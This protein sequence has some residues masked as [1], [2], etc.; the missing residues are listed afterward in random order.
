MI[1]TKVTAIGD[2]SNLAY[3]WV[4]CKTISLTT[5][6]MGRILRLITRFD[7]QIR[8]F[9]AACFAT[10]RYVRPNPNVSHDG[11]HEIIGCQALLYH[12][13]TL[14]RN[15]IA[16]RTSPLSLSLTRSVA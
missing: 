11:A 4:C 13:L 15:L 3:N 12:H 14:K 5:I 2:A 9:F 16:R 1:M 6:T 7:T 8:T 10:N